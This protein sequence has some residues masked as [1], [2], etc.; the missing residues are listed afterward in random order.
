MKN[1]K[2]KRKFLGFLILMIFAI[3]IFNIWITYNT[4]G[5]NGWF[6][7]VFTVLESYIFIFSTYYLLLTMFGWKK[8]TKEYKDADP[9]TKFAI[10]VPGHNE[11]KVI[12]EKLENCLKIDYPKEKFNIIVKHIN[13]YI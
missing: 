4:K 9:K 2:N 7:V 5:Y 13:Y 11:E 3:A 8:Y 1:E 10:I 6:D 12:R